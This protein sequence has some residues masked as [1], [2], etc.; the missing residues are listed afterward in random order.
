[1]IRRMKA[2]LLDELHKPYAVTARAKGLGP[3]RALLKYPFRMVLNPFVA[4]IGNM[5]PGLISGSVLVSL[6]LSLPTVGPILVQALRMQDQYLAGF[7]LLFVAVL[8]VVGMLIADL[9][10]ALIDPR[11][12]FGK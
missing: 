12:R 11:I 3:T 9:V 6:V 8:T 5:L 4:D 10:L 2:N 1:M 7:I